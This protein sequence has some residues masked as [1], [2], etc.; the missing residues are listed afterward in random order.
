M[1][2]RRGNYVYYVWKGKRYATGPTIIELGNTDLIFSTKILT[3]DP[4]KFDI[5]SN[6]HYFPV[7][8]SPDS[9]DLMWWCGD[10]HLQSIKTFY[11]TGRGQNLINGDRILQRG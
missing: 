6:L 10:Q 3:R 1:Y 2:K 11:N 7:T 9:S 8:K 4:L 5:K